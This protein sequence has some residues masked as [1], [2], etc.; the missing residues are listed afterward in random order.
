L[1]ADA[2]LDV[3]EDVEVALVADGNDDLTIVFASL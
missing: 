3:F 2:D 1:V